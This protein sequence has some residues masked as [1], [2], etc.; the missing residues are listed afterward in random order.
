MTALTIEN[1]QKAI[2]EEAVDGWLFYNFHHRDPLSDELLGLS[3]DSTNSRPWFYMVPREGEPIKI[4]HA[5]EAHILDQLSGSSLVYSGRDGI[6]KALQ[7]FAGKTLAVHADVNLPVISYLDAGTMQ[8]LVQAGI[9][10]VSA[11]SLIQRI[12]G[13]L[14]DEDLAS[15]K[16]AA[17]GLYEIV[18]DIWALVSKHYR[19]KQPLYE[20]D[21]QQAILV[22]M[23]E[24]NLVT[25]HPPIVAAGSHAGDPH[26]EVTSHGRLIQFGDVIQLDLW[27]KE[28]ENHSIYADIS[29][30][31]YYG[32]EIP[33]HI[34]KIFQDLV[35]SR[36]AA[37]SFITAQLNQGLRPTGAAVDREVRKFLVNRG[38]E[39]AIKHRTGHGIDTECH[40]SGVNID[41]VEFPDERKLLDGACFSIE[42]GLYFSEYG[43]RTEI[44]VY[45]QQHQAYVS[46]KMRQFALLTPQ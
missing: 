42:P 16:R 33:Q 39:G 12:K 28:I 46:G 10:T 20:G 1:L 37:L 44:D 32:T 45:I 36:E 23:K 9:Q 17:I 25:D 38:Y 41:S 14:S 34:Q 21:L 22:G 5:I 27:A 26:Y 31:G 7:C 18:E 13:I 40:G 4:V 19:T 24:R 11:A 29:W 30:V 15:H 2:R 43:F 3:R 8:N 6:T 35:D